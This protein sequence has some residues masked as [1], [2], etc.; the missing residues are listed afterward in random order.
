MQLD[1]FYSC[2]INTFFLL[3]VSIVSVFTIKKYDVYKKNIIKDNERNVSE[4]SKI[5]SNLTDLSEI[6]SFSN[7]LNF[8]SMLTQKEFITETLK[9][10]IF[11]L[12][13][14]SIATYYGY[15]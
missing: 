15:L 11:I 14:F 9:V 13:V 1:N 3:L 12:F 7:S 4:Q 2:I 6:H 10:F 5:N 8:W